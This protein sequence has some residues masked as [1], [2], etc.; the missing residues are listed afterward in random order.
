MDDRKKNEMLGRFI[1]RLAGGEP[2]DSVQSDLRKEFSYD[3]YAEPDGS[4]AKKDESAEAAETKAG[5][6]GNSDRGGRF[7]RQTAKSASVPGHPLNVLMLENREMRK[8]LYALDTM[9]DSGASVAE[10]A[11]GLA[12]LAEA[13]LHYDKKDELI[14]PLLRRHG[15]ARRAIAAWNDDSDLRRTTREL[16]EE[17]E[18]F[19]EERAAEGRD[20]DSDDEEEEEQ[21]DH[22]SDEPELDPEDQLCEDI[23]EHIANVEKN[24]DDEEHKIFPLAEK[25]FSDEEWQEIYSDFPRFGCAWLKDVPAW[26]GA[27]DGAAAGEGS[28]SEQS[29]EADQAEE[30]KTAEEEQTVELAGGTLTVSQLDGILRTLPAELTFIDELDTNRFFSEES[31]LFPRP[32]SALGR[33]VYECHPPKMV[34]VVQSVIADLRSGKK[35]TVQFITTKR[36]RKALVRYMAVR[37][38]DG[39]YIG[40]L[41]AVEDITDLEEIRRKDD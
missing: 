25:L 16:L 36:G 38:K 37:G 40:T 6:T 31:S 33:K 2:L 41:E 24:I 9:L 11:E 27:A 32:V 29:A 23:E 28:E 18:L 7:R 5:E 22:W 10:L 13:G 35:D 14:L 3:E 34:P 20:D 30:V 12:A 21:K 4:G 26:D 39:E 8:R 19:A 1:D 17:A 15:E